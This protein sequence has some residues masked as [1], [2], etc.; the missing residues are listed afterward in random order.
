[1]QLD[2]GRFSI[3]HRRLIALVD[4]TMTVPADWVID[5]KPGSAE[6]MYKPS[7]CYVTLD[8]GGEDSPE[9]VLDQKGM[10]PTRERNDLCVKSSTPGWSPGGLAV[11]LVRTYRKDQRDKARKAERASTKQ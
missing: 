1:M 10:K 3:V 8:G 11:N 7:G 2:G 5:V 6:A 4:I 9:F